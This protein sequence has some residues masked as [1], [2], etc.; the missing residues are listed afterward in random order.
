[1]EDNE[2]EE[3]ELEEEESEE[4]DELEEEESD[5][6]LLHQEW[7]DNWVD[8]GVTKK[9]STNLACVIAPVHDNHNHSDVNKKRAA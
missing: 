4:Q 9:Q 8:G 5:E 3:E 1:M 6:S 7:G 2:S